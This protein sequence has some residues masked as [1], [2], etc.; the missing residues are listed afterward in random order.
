MEAIEL[1]VVMVY[2]W[3]FISCDKY[4]TLV[5]HM[6]NGGVCMY[7]DW[8][9]IGNVSLPFSQFYCELKLLNQ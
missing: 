3:K 8:G 7:R 5:G 2:Q 6:D 4:V 9:Y 1:W